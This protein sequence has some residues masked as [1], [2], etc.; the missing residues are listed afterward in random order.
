[1]GVARTVLLLTA[2]TPYCW[3]PWTAPP[4]PLPMQA[5]QLKSDDNDEGAEI[6]KLSVC[7]THADQPGRFRTVHEAQAA[8]RQD[9]RRAAAGADATVRGSDALAV[10]ELCEGRHHL[11]SALVFEKV[12]GAVELRGIGGLATLDSGHRITGWTKS[13]ANA[14]VPGLWQATLPK[15]AAGSRQLWVKGRRANRAH[16]NPA[17]C[18]G[19]PAFANMPVP[20][21]AG[22]C[23]GT[24]R[25]GVRTA[26]G[27]SGVPDHAPRLSV[28]NASM[29]S[30]LSPGSE[31]VFGRGGSGASWT[32]PRCSVVNV[33]KGVTAGTVD[34]V[35]AQPCWARATTKHAPEQDVSFPSD[36]ENAFDLLDESGEWYADFSDGSVR[37]PGRIIYY[38]PREGERMDSP[39]T[40]VVLGGVVSGGG[41]GAAVVVQPGAAVR[42][43]ERLA[44]QYQTWSARP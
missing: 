8:L 32:E 15:T 13:S 18:S 41:G 12:D 4:A 42:R 31:L 25:A 36:I 3:T 33:S 19:G 21:F 16:A 43:I 2:W 14:A 38:L 1:M 28:G 26:A 34:I 35:M 39:S 24:F 6:V 17:N 10:F 5:P 23:E 7:P 44:F 37:Q 30:W 40:V 27:Y 22:A 11:Q 20:P 29:T 9:R